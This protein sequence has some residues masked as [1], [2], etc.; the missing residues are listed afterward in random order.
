MRLFAQH[1]YNT[2]QLFPKPWH[3]VH[4]TPHYQHL[5]G[6]GDYRKYLELSWDGRDR[7]VDTKLLEFSELLESIKD[8]GVKE[9]IQVCRRFDNQLLIF[10]GN[11][12]Y[13]C[14]RYLGMDCPETE[15]SVEEYIRTNIENDKY[16]FGTKDGVPYQ[17]VYYQGNLLINGRRRDLLQRQ[18]LIDPADLKG[19]RVFD[20]GC[21][22]GMSCVMAHEAGAN[23]EGWDY[24][25]I[26]TSAIRLAVLFG[27]DIKY[28]K[29]R[30]H[31]DTA[32]FFSVHSHMDV[33][34]IDADVLYVETHEDGRLPKS[35]REGRSTKYLGK[36]GKRRLYRMWRI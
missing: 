11:H 4:D 14:A 8:Q 27:Y 9:P 23:V 19:K 32:F 24:P 3:T 21:N 34:K 29:P 35:F 18:A 7:C 15:I 17:P 2:W 5:Q 28:Q 1:K 33:P 31:Y 30:G 6:G 10:H 36:L 13:A 25:E 20:F 26:M 22:L 16:R 12:R